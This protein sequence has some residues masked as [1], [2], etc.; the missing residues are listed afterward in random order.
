MSIWIV[1]GQ[2]ESYDNWEVLGVL[3]DEAAVEVRVKE[4]LTEYMHYNHVKVQCWRAL[5]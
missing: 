5:A 1:L 3:F 4:I 2:E